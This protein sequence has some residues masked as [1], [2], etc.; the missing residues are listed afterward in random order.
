M[1]SAYQSLSADE[2]RQ[3]ML[4][5]PLLRLADNLDRSHEQKI[6]GVDC[7]LNDGQ[8]VLQVHSEGDVDLEQWGAERAGEAFQQIYN[9][10]VHVTKARD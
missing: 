3:L 9:R 6:H 5:I 7:R 8:V 4:S 2:K 1:H 10:E